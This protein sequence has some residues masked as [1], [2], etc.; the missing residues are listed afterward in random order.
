[1][2]HQNTHASKKNGLQEAEYANLTE[3]FGEVKK[4]EQGFGP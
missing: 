1:M 2:P 3:P 4:R